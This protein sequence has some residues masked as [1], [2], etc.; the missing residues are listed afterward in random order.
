[1]EATGKFSW[2]RPITSYTR[3]HLFVNK[4]F[5]PLI[6]NIPFLVP[7]KLIKD[8]EYLQ[9]GCGYNIFENF[10]NT[11]IEWKP[12]VLPWDISTI[13]KHNY[14]IKT[15]QLKGIYTE[16]CLEH[17]P[18]NAVVNNLKEFYRILKP[19]GTV[20]IAVPDGE[21]FIDA[22]AKSKNNEPF[23]IP[24]PEELEER[25]VM[26]TLNKVARGYGH[27]FLYDFE[28][29]EL[30]LKEA[31]FKN[32]KKETYRSGRDTTLLVDSE[33]RRAESLYV[34]ATK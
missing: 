30:I 12:G 7:Q 28:T 15:N 22:Y 24:H 21:I 8:K 33:L 20:R 2:N 16:H 27:L 13:E 29:M 31:G 14:P 34:E 32:I 11:D 4:Y 26:M 19:G 17:I 1:M 6:I 23:S 10:I 5:T 25:T 3:F 18:F 9:V